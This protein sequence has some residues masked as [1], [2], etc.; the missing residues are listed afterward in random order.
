MTGFGVG[1][2]IMPDR[3]TLFCEE[4]IE[5]FLRLRI[6]NKTAAASVENNLSYLSGQ[7]IHREKK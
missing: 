5:S 4:L 7:V 6:E 3:L 2:K 1:H